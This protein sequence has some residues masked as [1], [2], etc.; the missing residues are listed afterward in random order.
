MSHNLTAES[1]SAVHHV[2]LRT[3]TPYVNL[4]YNQQLFSAIVGEHFGVTP[5]DIIPMAGTMGAIEAVRNHVSRIDQRGRHTVLTVCPGY[6]RARESFEGFGFEVI[7]IKTE[8]SGFTI[9]E[10]ALVEKAWEDNP[11]LVYLSLPNNPTGALFDPEIVVAGMPETPAIMLDLTLPSRDMD[12][13]AITARLYDRFRGRQNLFLVGSTSKSHATAE[14][15]VGWAMCASSEDAEQLRRENRNVVASVSI[16]QAITRLEQAPTVLDSI[17]RS[18]DLLREGERQKRFRIVTPERMT[19]TGYVL[20]RSRVYAEELRTTFDK[21][22]MRVMW[23]SEFG[24]ADQYIR[25]ETSEPA[26]I[27]VFVDAINT[28]LVES[29]QPH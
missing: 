14:Y 7:T 17:E 8:S 3:G 15:R 21:N 4:I 2:E 6:W 13:R 22:R 1:Q 18:F 12:S 25:L 5:S 29:G 28:C 26:N 23:G 27:K 11:S 24:L 20:I 9:S 16:A 10:A 19:E